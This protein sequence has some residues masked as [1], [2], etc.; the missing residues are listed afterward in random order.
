MHTAHAGTSEIAIFGRVLEPEEAK[1]V[2][3]AC[4]HYRF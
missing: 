1:L 3:A 2:V 4:E